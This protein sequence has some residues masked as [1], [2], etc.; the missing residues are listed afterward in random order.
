MRHVDRLPYETFQRLKKHYVGKMVL[1][2]DAALSAPG[3]R[4]AFSDH[5]DYLRHLF[6]K[7]GVEILRFAH[8]YDSLSTSTPELGVVFLANDSVVT[9]GVEA[10]VLIGHNARYIS[11][12]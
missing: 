4:Q 10:W 6:K 12:G 3:I 7:Q 8:N 11:E 2:D 5:R 1:L 9:P